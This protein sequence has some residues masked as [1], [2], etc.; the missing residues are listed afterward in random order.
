[1]Q[2]SARI[3]S[4]LAVP[5]ILMS[6]A[7]ATTSQKVVEQMCAQEP[8]HSGVVGVLA[9]TSLGDTLVCFNGGNC[10][11]PASNMKLLTCGAALNI[12]G[13]GYRYRTVIAYS[14]HISDGVLTGNVYIV[15]EGD[16]T[17]AADG[18]EVDFLF[19]KWKQ[20]LDRAGIRRIDGAVIGDGEYFKS[21][22]GNESWSMYDRSRSYGATVS[23]LNFY[24][25]A[26]KFHLYAPRD[27]G[28]NVEFRV[29]YPQTPWM[30]FR[31]SCV[32]RAA[33]KA[34]GVSFINTGI[35]HTAEFAGSCRAGRGSFEL[36][37]SNCFPELT[38]A[39]YFRNYL[40]DN[41]IQVSD[42]LSGSSRG[43]NLTRLGETYSEPLQ[44]IVEQ[45]LCHSDNFYAE[46]LLRTVGHKFGATTQ[47]LSLQAEKD[48]LKQINVP[49]KGYLN[50]VD[51]SGLSRKN[52][53]SPS[54]FVSFLKA[55]MKTPEYANFV[56]A[57]PRPGQGTLEN[58]MKNC[59]VSARCRVAMKSGSM[60]GTLCFSGYILPENEDT[61]Q[62][63][64]FSIM[65]NNVNGGPR[66]AGP[67]I[68]RILSTLA[69]EI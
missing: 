41:G 54:F 9:V 52:Y 68:D 64:V 22:A 35:A 3:L 14:G 32:T 7:P 42:Y 6:S 24:E 27:I 31:N 11:V 50:P 49:V 55:M 45:T 57:L 67:I 2:M 23:G 65:T 33:D 56:R 47:E 16:P 58:R 46:T 53:A 13:S 26:Q 69:T 15:G 28:R 12:L 8:L 30:E 18:T 25:N 66:T 37:A 5:V 4:M 19:G 29:D 62:V 43:V 17:I 34:E 20:M 61:D 48:W 21:V 63:I 51:G 1:M 39:Y 44:S 10:M 36:T 60:N 59:D 38:C 40:L